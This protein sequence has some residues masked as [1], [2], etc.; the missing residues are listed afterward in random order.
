MNNLYM[1]SY[2]PFNQTRRQNSTYTAELEHITN[3][4]NILT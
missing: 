1:I 4:K 3:M 2:W